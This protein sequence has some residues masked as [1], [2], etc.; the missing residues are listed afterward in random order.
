[1]DSSPQANLPL[2]PLQNLAT[3]N[4]AESSRCVTSQGDKEHLGYWCS[5]AVKR[6]L[7]VAYPVL[8]KFVPIWTSTL[9]SYDS[10]ID[11]LHLQA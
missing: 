10:A 8:S 11:V 3:P 2:D 6:G 4:L 7:R 1:M 9:T 5:Q